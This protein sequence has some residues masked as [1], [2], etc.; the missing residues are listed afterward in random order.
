MHTE[1][2]GDA[3]EA[4]QGRSLVTT[5]EAGRVAEGARA[6]HLLLLSG[7]RLTEL[8]VLSLLRRLD[9]ASAAE[10]LRWRGK[11]TRL[12]RWNGMAASGSVHAAPR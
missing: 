8:L 7:E 9:P 12:W 2:A 10:R 11:T 3:P 1:L 6:S 5:S 4:R